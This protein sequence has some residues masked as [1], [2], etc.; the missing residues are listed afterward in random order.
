MKSSHTNMTL[1]VDGLMAVPN[2]CKDRVLATVLLHLQ[3]AR[4]RVVFQNKSCIVFRPPAIRTSLHPVGTV[5]VGTVGLDD[6]GTQLQYRLLLSGVRNGIVVWTLIAAIIP[7]ILG[8]SR[9][10]HL[11]VA[12]FVPAVFI[13]LY[14]INRAIL[15]ARFEAIL[16]KSI[17]DTDGSWHMAVP[18]N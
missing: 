14:L 2:R 15:R 18:A 1:D 17:S 5:S 8:A 7:G 6:T 12:L 9:D 13:M 10:T 3:S 16:L 4:C 11:I